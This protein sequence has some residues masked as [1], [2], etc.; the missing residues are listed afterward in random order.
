MLY[1]KSDITLSLPFIQVYS[2]KFSIIIYQEKKSIWRELRHSMMVLCLFLR[3]PI[4]CFFNSFKTKHCSG[5]SL[6]DTKLMNYLLSWK[7]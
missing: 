4:P 7:S 5:F 2:M 6:G 1:N 3:K